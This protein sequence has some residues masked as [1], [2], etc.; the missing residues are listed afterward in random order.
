MGLYHAVPGY[1]DGLQAVR[2]VGG[3]EGSGNLKIPL[4]GVVFHVPAP[5]CGGFLIQ[6]LYFY[7]VRVETGRPHSGEKPV[8]IDIVNLG[9]TIKEIT[10]E[11]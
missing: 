9:K 3:Y 2:A 11:L 10:G 8:Q 6:Q 1:I 4:F 7:G 5:P